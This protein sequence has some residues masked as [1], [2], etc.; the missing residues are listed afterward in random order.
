MYPVIFSLGIFRLY[1]INVFLFLAGFFALFTFWK[2]IKDNGLFNE[3]VSFDWFLSGAFF[4]F[5]FGRIVYILI[6]FEI[7]HFDFVKMI[8]FFSYPGINIFIYLIFFAIFLFR[9]VIK[10]K[11]DRFEILDFWSPAASISLSLYYLGMFLSGSMIGKKTNFIFGVQLNNQVAKTHPTALYFSLFYFF[12]F[13]FLNFLES[14]YRHFIWYRNKKQTA[15]TGFLFIIS[16]ILTSLF[17]LLML[18]FWQGEFAINSFVL[19][20]FLYPLLFFYGIFLLMLR[21]NRLKFKL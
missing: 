21:S 16:I 11:L 13:L 20:W 6:N 2:K 10:T 17:S 19:D 8:R 18:L 7:F 1:T 9:F 15:K 12:L 14:R 3:Y 5:L 4:G